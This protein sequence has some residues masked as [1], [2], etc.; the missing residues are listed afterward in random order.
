MKTTRRNFFKNA[1]AGVGGAFALLFAGKTPAKETNGPGLEDTRDAMMYWAEWAIA[2]GSDTTGIRDLKAYRGEAVWRAMY[3]HMSSLSAFARNDYSQG[4]K[5]IAA[6]KEWGQL[7]C[8]ADD[9]I[10]KLS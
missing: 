3:E 10:K 1:I 6:A 4:A 5:Y 9:S 8:A 2:T 7:A